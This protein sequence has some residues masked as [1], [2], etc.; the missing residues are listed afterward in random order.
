MIK[1]RIPDRGDVYEINP[2]PVAGHEMKDKHRFIVITPKEIN[3][4]GIAMTV[5]V[6][7]AGHFS[8]S[9]GLCVVI[10]GH[11]TTGVAVCNQVRSFDIQAR[12]KNGS[13]KFIETIETY[14]ITEIINRVVSII[15]P[16][17]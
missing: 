14:L 5:P 9:N 17:P 6:T 8:R 11:D 12:E 4:L 15:D 7:S 13:A 3:A 1:K 10:S 2:N 16:A